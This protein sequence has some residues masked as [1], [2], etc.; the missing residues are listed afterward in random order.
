LVASYLEAERRRDAAAVAEHFCTDG[1]LV[2]ANGARHAG[3]MAVRRVYE[4]IYGGLS[5]LDVQLVGEVLDTD[6]GAIEWIADAVGTDGVVVH[7]R[8]VSVV[9]MHG[10]GFAEVRVYLGSD[11]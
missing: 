7:L 2:D 8:G 6:R 11:P 10:R 3:R 9:R 1:V 5:G 4:G